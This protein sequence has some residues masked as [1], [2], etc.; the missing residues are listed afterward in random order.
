[1]STPPFPAVLSQAELPLPLTGYRR[2]LG[3]WIHAGPDLTYVVDPGPAA[4]LPRLL[5]ALEERGVR[6]LD[7]ILLTHVHLDH[8][9]GAGGLA[10]R[11][12]KAAVLCTERAWR[13]LVDPGRLWEASLAVLGE[14]ARVM[15]E[16]DPVPADRLAPPDALAE[17]GIAWIPAP[18]HASHHGCYRHGPVLFVAE[19]AGVR[20]PLPGGRRYLRPATP[21]PFHPAVYWE[22]L[23]RL[24]REA[25][26][27]P[28]LAFAHFGACP[29]GDLLARAER[30][31]RRWL[32]AV[33]RSVAEEGVRRWSPAW[34]AALRERLLGE[35]PDFASFP[36]LP[37]DIRRREDVYLRNTFT[38]MLDAVLAN[39]TPDQ[40]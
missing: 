17:R 16:P 20:Y 1:V 39:R 2:F 5:A 10:R 7:A 33:S 4:T 37:E 31:A 38:G 40:A 12:P 15:G 21:P 29:A 23:A 32:S 19:A 28:W 11:F 6:H 36:E 24:R 35:D 8:A 14:I 13:H 22:S 25:G 27:A 26:D 3:C 18:G 30:Q 9:G 34:Q